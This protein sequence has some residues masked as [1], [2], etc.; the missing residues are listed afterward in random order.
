[1]DMVPCKHGLTKYRAYN[2]KL[3]L[4]KKYFCKL[5]FVARTEIE[6]TA[7]NR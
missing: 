1:M 4:D 2:I 7:L 6:Q 5:L 3:L